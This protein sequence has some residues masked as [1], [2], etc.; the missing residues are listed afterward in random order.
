[1]ERVVGAL[2]VLGAVCAVVLLPVQALASQVRGQPLQ[3]DG[4]DDA[5]STIWGF[6]QGNLGRVLVAGGLAGAVG[7]AWKGYYGA[8]A[9]GAGTSVAGVFIPSTSTR[10]MDNA[11]AWDG[12]SFLPPLWQGT[13]GDWFVVDPVCL[14]LLFGLCLL[15]LLRSRQPAL[16]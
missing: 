2:L 9:G 6:A 11:P 12:G 14:A 7:S 1:M 8:A 4:M 10:L 16:R 13:L 3:M 5:T 15:V